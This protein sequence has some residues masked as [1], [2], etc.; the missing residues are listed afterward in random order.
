MLF[1]VVIVEKPTKKA[2]EDGAVEKII[3]G[4]K[5]ISARDREHA[6]TLALLDQDFVAGDAAR[7]RVEVIVRPFA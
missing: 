4:P 7:P 5:T 2:E 1:D 6:K 3:F